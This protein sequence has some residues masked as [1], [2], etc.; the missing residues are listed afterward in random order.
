MKGEEIQILG[1]STVGEWAS[2]EEAGQPTKASRYTG[3][4]DDGTTGVI[5]HVLGR[6][7]KNLDPTFSVG[8]AGKLS[9]V[10]S[11]KSPLPGPPCPAQCSINQAVMV[12]CCQ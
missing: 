12:A 3:R 10:L 4:G 5:L 9:M 2:P 11:P 7:R 1:T 8:G 6:G